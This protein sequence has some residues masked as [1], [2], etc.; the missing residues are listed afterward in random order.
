[1]SEALKI[2]GEA[3]PALTE[4]VQVCLLSSSSRWAGAWFPAPQRKGSVCVS[5]AA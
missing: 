1:M 2:T 5:R 3:S 4:L